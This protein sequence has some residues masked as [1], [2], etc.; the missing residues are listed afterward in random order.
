[1]TSERTPLSD[2]PT[3]TIPENGHQLLFGRSSSSCHFQLPYNRLI[4]RVHVGVT[5]L[6]PTREY[7]SGR[8]VIEC[9]GWNGCKVLCQGRVEELSKESVLMLSNPAAEIILDVLD[10]RVILAWPDV[11]PVHSFGS[12]SSWLNYSP[13][14]RPRRTG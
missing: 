6:S 12:G 10:T 3:V 14:R 1:S 9:M 13:S 4:S 8:V 2:V 5:F 11:D 7:A